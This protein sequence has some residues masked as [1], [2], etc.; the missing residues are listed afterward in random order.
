MLRLIGVPLTILDIHDTRTTISEL[1]AKAAAGEEVLIS[2]EGRTVARLIGM[3]EPGS[4]VDRMKAFGMFKDRIHM[5]HFDD[6]LPED[7]QRALGM[8]E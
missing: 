5:E 7:I 6:P 4:G 3:P 8:T 2:K 1:V